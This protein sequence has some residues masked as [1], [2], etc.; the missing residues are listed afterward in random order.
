MHGCSGGVC[1]SQRERGQ[2]GSGEPHGAQCHPR[3]SE[4]IRGHPR[5]S[6]AIRGHPRSSEAIRGH[7]RPSASSDTCAPEYTSLH[8]ALGVGKPET[9]VKPWLCD[10]SQVAP[11]RSHHARH[12]PRGKDL[13]DERRVGRDEGGRP[14]ALWGLGSARG[15]AAVGGQ[16]PLASHA[17]PINQPRRA[18]VSQCEPM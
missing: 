8:T 4:A 11:R 12:P 15:Q 2:Q 17:E 14:R 9:G 13:E 5:P 7:P 6:E 18:N 1:G 3:P 10:G 16:C